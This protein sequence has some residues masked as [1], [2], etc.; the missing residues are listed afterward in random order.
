MKILQIVPQVPLPLND[1][2]KLGIHGITR[3]LANRGH[4]IHFVCYRKNVDKDWAE[5]ELEKIC[6]PYIL[7]VQTENKMLPALA[8]LFSPVP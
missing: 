4:E 8:N 2:G 6:T 7:D 5:K 1:G 3:S